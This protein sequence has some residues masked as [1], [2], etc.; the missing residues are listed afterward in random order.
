MPYRGK[1]T[2]PENAVIPEPTEED[3]EMLPKAVVI[4]KSFLSDEIKEKIIN[5]LTKEY[6]RRNNR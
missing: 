3:K 6:E 4:G 2:Y 1:V 5:Y